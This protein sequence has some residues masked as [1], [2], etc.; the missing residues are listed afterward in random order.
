MIRSKRTQGAL[1]LAAALVLAALSMLLAGTQ[2]VGADHGIPLGAERVNPVV[3]GVVAGVLALAV[4]LVVV[5][6]A[7]LLAR[8]PPRAP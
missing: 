5:A 3:V 6:I 4:G 8:K 1:R 7:T 2:P